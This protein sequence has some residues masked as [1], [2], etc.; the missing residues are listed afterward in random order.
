MIINYIL[1][2]HLT[3]VHGKGDDDGKLKQKK[4]DGFFRCAPK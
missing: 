2:D 4:I 1:S 3:T